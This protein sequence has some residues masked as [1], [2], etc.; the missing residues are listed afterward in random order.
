MVNRY[1]SHRG[2]GSLD[3][4]L[5]TKC[6]KPRGRGRDG[7]TQLVYHKRSERDANYILKNYR[8]RLHDR[9]ANAG[10]IFPSGM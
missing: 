7:G 3:D 6:V 4:S 8:G 5:C 9:G 2:Y 1:G 10:Q